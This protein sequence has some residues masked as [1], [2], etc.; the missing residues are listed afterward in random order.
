M[1]APC[2]YHPDTAAAN[3]CVQCGVPI[4]N[5]CTDRVGEKTVCRKCVQ[6]VR[7]RLESHM[8]A[9]PASG[10]YAPPPAQGYQPGNYAGRPPMRD[11]GVFGGSAVV[12]PPEPVNVSQMIL[13]IAVAAVIGIIGAIITEKIL[14]TTGFGISYLYIAIGYGVGFGLHKVI[15]RGGPGMATLAVGIMIFGLL[16]GQLVYTA[17]MLG[18]FR[19]D[20]PSMAG[21]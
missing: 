2:Y 16:V 13:G 14:F 18:K 3:T 7:T 8:A 20:D 4:C 21:V 1:P 6:A 9:A 10:Q 5:D 19:A 12:L 17:D 15:G 11:G